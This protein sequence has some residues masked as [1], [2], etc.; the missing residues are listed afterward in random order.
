MLVLVEKC[1]RVIYWSVTASLTLLF[2]CWAG[3]STLAQ[4]SPSSSSVETTAIPSRTRTARPPARRGWRSGRTPRRLPQQRSGVTP[5]RYLNPVRD[6]ESKAE[7]PPEI[8]SG[9]A[10]VAVRANEN[11]TIRLGLAQGGLT[12]VEFPAKDR[13]FAIHPADSNLV[14]IDDSPTK[15]QDRFFVFRP[16]SGFVASPLTNGSAARVPAASIMV[17]MRSGLTVTFLVYPVRDLT[18]NAH[19]VVVMYDPAA[20]VSARRMAGL[21]V[22]LGSGE[23]EPKLPAVTSIRIEPPVSLLPLPTPAPAPDYRAATRRALERF[24]AYVATRDAK[25]VPGLGAFGREVSGLKVAAAEVEQLGPNTRMAVVAVYNQ[26]DRTVRLAQTTP[27]FAIETLDARGRA[28]E[29]R[30][31][32]TIAT[33]TTATV[34]AAGSSGGEIPSRSTVY[35]AIV[36]EVS[37]P[38]GARQVLRAL[39]SSERAAD[40]PAMAEVAR[41]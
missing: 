7:A 11:P 27:E 14:T 36:Y 41:N 4:Q 24:G 34:T 9:E 2:F 39:A 5:V 1:S 29:R 35:Y 18:R 30:P 12:L 10:Q 17:Q 40:R 19:R 33:G 20:V 23:E 15:Q 22:N 26:S 38:L 13:F 37:G 21:A 6:T 16:G 28:Q 32:K 25:Q 3:A 8:Y 31:V